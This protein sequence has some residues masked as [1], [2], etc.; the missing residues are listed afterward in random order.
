MK[1]LVDAQLPMRLAQL[2]LN[3]G[4]DVVHS[5]QLPQCNR[6]RDDVLAELADVE[7]RVVVTKN[8]DFEIGHLL[9]GAL[10]NLLL[11]TTG[12]VGNNDLLDLFGVNLAL[13]E[14]AL[15]QNSYVELSATTV[16]VHGGA[17]DR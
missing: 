2:L 7:G 4:H 10:R 9:N 8:R 14:A 13:I 12:N 11:V 3:A 5:S 17:A 1:F 16:I 6:T 15:D